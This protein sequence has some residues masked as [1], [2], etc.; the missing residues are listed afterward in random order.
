MVEKILHPRDGEN[1]V[2]D[3]LDMC[4]GD[5]KL[6]KKMTKARNNYYDDYGHE[7]L[8]MV[9]E[10]VAATGLSVKYFKQS[11]LNLVKIGTP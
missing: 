8:K 2:S 4:D 6:Y 9:E 1:I 11:D 7:E 5:E 3:M 10:Y